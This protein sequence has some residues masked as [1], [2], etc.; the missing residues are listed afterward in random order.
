LTRL[1]VVTFDRDRWAV[2][3]QMELLHLLEYPHNITVWCNEDNREWYNWFRSVQKRFPLDYSVRDY[4]EIDCL[5]QTKNPLWKRGYYRQQIVKLWDARELGST[6]SLDSKTWLISRNAWHT[7]NRGMHIRMELKNSAFEKT[8]DFCKH[9]LGYSLDH[10]PVNMP[11]IYLDQKTVRRLGKFSTLFSEL[12]QYDFKQLHTYN[13]SEYLLYQTRSAQLGYQE[14]EG[15]N[16]FT[17]Y[18]LNNLTPAANKLRK[19]WY[20][21]HADYD[22]FTV[23]WHNETAPIDRDKIFSIVRAAVQY[24]NRKQ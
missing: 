9:Y 5:T 2:E 20:S 4:R 7:T 8:A 12:E 11:P 13:F 21:G 1:T 16:I 3:K 17:L 6:V 23:K 22:W 19:H 18:T 15:V 14:T 10:I 24:K